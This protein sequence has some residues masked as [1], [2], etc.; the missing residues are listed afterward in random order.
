V[1]DIFI[2]DTELSLEAIFAWNHTC[3]GARLADLANIVFILMPWLAFTGG[4]WWLSFI[5]R[6]KSHHSVAVMFLVLRELCMLLT[7]EEKLSDCCL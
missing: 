1:L 7:R 3:R 2:S 5:A 4:Q 6:E